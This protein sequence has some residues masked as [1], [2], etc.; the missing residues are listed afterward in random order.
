MSLQP[1]TST[2]VSNF[3]A[4]VQNV[5]TSGILKLVT[6]YRNDITKAC[7]KYALCYCI[8]KQVIAECGKL[9]ITTDHCIA[10]GCEAAW[11]GYYHG[12]DSIAGTLAKYA[13]VNFCYNQIARA[14]QF[15]GLDYPDSIKS[16][17]RL[18]FVA[19]LVVPLLVRQAISSSIDYFIHTSDENENDYDALSSA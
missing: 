16:N 15:V 7:A 3:F 6:T 4:P 18:S 1:Q 9:Q 19:G 12:A 10:Y 14:A 2:R 5:L 8:Q 13:C 17:F 11:A